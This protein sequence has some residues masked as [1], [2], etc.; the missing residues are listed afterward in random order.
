[1]E[2][3]YGMSPMETVEQAKAEFEDYINRIADADPW[4]K[5]HHP[6]VEWLGCCWHP[7]SMD[8]DDA[9]VQMVAANHEAVVGNDATICGIAVAADAGTVFEFLETRLYSLAPERSPWRIR[10]TNMSKSTK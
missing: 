2:I 7:Y 6:V 4:L 8:T 3:R 1:M 10:Q 9:F 5:D